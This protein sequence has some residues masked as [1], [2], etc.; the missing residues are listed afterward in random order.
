MNKETETK[1]EQLVLD[2]PTAEILEGFWFYVAV[3][4][5]LIKFICLK[6][7]FTKEGIDFSTNRGGFN[8]LWL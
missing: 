4:K 1:E 7:N 5:V 8:K 3:Y 2:G 6:K